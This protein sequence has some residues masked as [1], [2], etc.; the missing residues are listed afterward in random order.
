MAA[1]AV[2]GAGLTGLVTAYRLKQRGSRVVVY[3]AGDRIGGAIKTLRRD[4]YLAELGPSSLAA[5]SASVATLL[6]DLGLDAARLIASSAARN[7]YIVRRG[8]LIRLPMSPAELLTSRL[9][10]NGAKLAIFGEPLMDAGD[11]PMEESIAA[12]VRRRFNQEVLDYVVNPFIAGIFAGDPEQLSVRHATPKLYALERNHGSV[13]K[14]LAPIMRAQRE[15]VPRGAGPGAVVS[16]RGGLQELPDSLGRTLTTEVRL[17][18]PVTQLRKGPRGWTVGAAFQTPELFDAVVY[19]APAHSLDEIDLDLDGS[20]RL[21]TLASIFHP[22]VAVVALGFRR[23]QVAHPLDG[24]GFLTPEVERKR[25]LG[26]VFSSSLF[27]E[28]A[29]EGHVLVTAFVGGTRDPDLVHADPQ[30]LTARVLDD[31]RSLLG[32]SGEPSFRALQVWPKAIPQYVLGYGRFKEI[33]E[34]VERR[35]PG[36][37]LAGTYRDGV[38]LGDAITSAE[39]A[40]ARVGLF[41]ANDGMAAAGLPPDRGVATA[42][43]D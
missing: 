17:R 12:F 10:S 21:S 9:L 40:A 39:Q 16:F 7:R 5:P 3:E 13:M 11:S 6:A 33:A 23:D 4:G 26:V 1:I 8:R 28:R 32:S 22:P 14:A 34:E 30:T 38:S 41:L 35:N 20:E 2:V 27:P 24:F 31:L 37:V 29:P 18:S 42:G 43:Q 25:I 19:A 36:L 15:P